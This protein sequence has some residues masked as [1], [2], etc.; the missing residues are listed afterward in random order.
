MHN[1]CSLVSYFRSYVNCLLIVGELYVNY[2]VCFNALRKFRKYA[3][4]GFC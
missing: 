2:L 3:N 4:S 1:F